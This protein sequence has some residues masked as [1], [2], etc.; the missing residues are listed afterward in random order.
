MKEM[1]DLRSVPS[2]SQGMGK[3]LMCTEG[4]V[5]KSGKTLTVLVIV[6]PDGGREIAQGSW[7]WGDVI[8]WEAYA[9]SPALHLRIHMSI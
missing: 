8:A 1:L 7:I 9:D 6:H 3:I 5:L 2:V 4:M